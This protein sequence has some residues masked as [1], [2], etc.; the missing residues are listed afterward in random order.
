M[1]TESHYINE[2]PT[3]SDE[4]IMWKEENTK[5]VT[6]INDISRIIKWSRNICVSMFV[7]MFVFLLCIKLNA[8]QDLDMVSYM[9][10]GIGNKNEG[11]YKKRSMKYEVVENKNEVDEGL[12]DELPFYTRRRLLFNS[13]PTLDGLKNVWEPYDTS[14]FPIFIHFAK[15]GGTT[16]KNVLSHCHHKVLASEVGIRDGHSEDK[17]INIV[18]F[19][20]HPFVNVDTSTAEGIERAHRMNFAHSHLA[21][22]TVT[23]L[24]H[25]IEKLFSTQVFGR[26]R[27]FCIF[28]NPIERAISMFYYLQYADWET[29]Y[30]PALNNMTLDE[31]VVSPHNV[32]SDYMTRILSGKYFGKLTPHDFNVAVVILKRKILIGLQSKMNES[33]ER[34]EQFFEWKF[35]SRDID[36]Q[37]ECRSNLVNKGSNVNRKKY[38]IPDE[39]TK[40]YQMLYERNR[41]DMQLY[42]IAISVF[43]QQQYLVANIPK[44]T[45]LQ[46]FNSN[47]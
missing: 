42:G 35:V 4:G 8:Q 3:D 5:A 16:I 40:L 9:V 46:G 13:L 37:E 30:N 2:F 6:N 45:R 15:N 12:L 7:L 24:I 21:D 31:Y 17:E 22:V 18:L 39:N 19:H 47:I 28:R 26:G 11:D 44:N 34:F 36:A 41:Y 14:D 43:D 10:N 33:M 1:V 20:G 29:S 38:I 25:E 23:P 32:E 27:L